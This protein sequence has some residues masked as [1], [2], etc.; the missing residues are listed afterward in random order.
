M[1]RQW[2]DGGFLEEGHWIYWDITVGQ[3]LQSI[4]SSK[5]GKQFAYTADNAAQLN[6]AFAAI[7]DTIVSGLDTGTVRD[8]L[9]T[10]GI[11]AKNA[12]GEE[13]EIPETWDLEKDFEK[14][15]EPPT[16]T[17]D[18]KVTTYTY[19]KTYYVTIDPDAVGLNTTKI[20]N[21]LYAPLNGE[22]TL[23]VEVAGEEKTIPFPIPAGKVTP[24][25]YTV[26]GT[27]DN[28]GTVNSAASPYTETVESGKT[29]KAMTFTPAAGYE[30]KTIT[31]KIGDG[32]PATITVTDKNSYT[33]PAKGNVNANITVDVKTAKRSDLKY[34]VKHV[35]KDN[36]TNVLATRD[37]TGTLDEV[38]HGEA[39]K[40]NFTGFTYAEC[41]PESI[42][43]SATEDNNVITLY[44]T[45]NKYKVTYTYTG[46]V[47][48][49]LQ[50]PTETVY[51]FDASVTIANNPT[52]V[53]GYTFEGWKRGT[54]AATSFS[55]P[56]ENV[57]IT[58][59]WKKNDDAGYK[60]EYYLE[61]LDGQSFVI[62]DT[63]TVNDK[64]GTIGTTASV[65]EADKKQITGFTF[66]ANNTNNKLEGEIVSGDPSR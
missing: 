60:I 36:A 25:Q 24:K 48:Q 38:I 35:E 57:T 39:Q 49:G 50:P 42:K 2:D 34:V 8:K 12:S 52:A 63:L 7:T 43:I 22:T 28:K 55:M 10:A 56:A 51:D 64:T 40:E 16:T 41:S 5:A 17:G 18:K 6:T 33:Y 45:R 15:T 23:T 4:A 47:P 27:I 14:K 30:I 46:S 58:G 53:P 26:T 21:D 61:S 31:E 20:G 59:N 1:K 37:K 19:T 13:I 11:T 9:P 32:Q 54:D 65:T 29:S 62:D 66:D 3:Y 44:Y